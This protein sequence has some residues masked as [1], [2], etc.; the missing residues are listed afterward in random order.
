MRKRLHP[1]SILGLAFNKAAPPPQTVA[2]LDTLVR[3]S[4]KLCT[5][6]VC[7]HRKYNRFKCIRWPH[8]T[9]SLPSHLT[10]NHLGNTVFAPPTLSSRAAW[11]AKGLGLVRNTIS[12]FDQPLSHLNDEQLA[13]TLTRLT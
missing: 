6:D 7:T 5:C 11:P 2:E 10:I 8:I 13:A 3:A 4:N 12:Y 1:T 9:I